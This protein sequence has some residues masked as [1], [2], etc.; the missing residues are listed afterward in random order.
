MGEMLLLQITLYI[1]LPFT[2]FIIFLERAIWMDYLFMYY[3]VLP[4]ISGFYVLGPFRCYL[5]VGR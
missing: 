1:F 3:N 2:P 4:I 5:L